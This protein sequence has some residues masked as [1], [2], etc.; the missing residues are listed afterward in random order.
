M[1]RFIDDEAVEDREVPTNSVE[2]VDP[3]SDDAEEPCVVCGHLVC[4]CPLS[5]DG[6][7][8][9]PPLARSYASVGF[10]APFTPDLV[11]LRH[12]EQWRNTYLRCQ[13]DFASFAEEEER[14]PPNL[15]SYFE[16]FPDLSWQDVVRICRAHANALQA[17]HAPRGPYKKHKTS[18]ARLPGV[19]G[20]KRS[21]DF[22]K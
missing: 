13:E 9:V 18:N 21:L 15:H 17:T 22:S 12:A 20:T 5:Q 8:V 3:P 2:E 19:R 16:S 11:I 1:S 7:Q 14:A 4:E 6:E 10:K